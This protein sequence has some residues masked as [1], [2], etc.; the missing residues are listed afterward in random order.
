MLLLDSDL[1]IERANR[2]AQ[3]VFGLDPQEIIGRHS[4]EVILGVADPPPECPAVRM[5]QSGRRETAEL[6]VG[7]RWF[8]VV[9]DPVYDDAGVLTHAVYCIDDITERK[10]ADEALKESE[11]H[12]HESLKFQE[13][14]LNTSSI[15]I[16][17]YRASGQCVSANEAAAGII[18]ATVADL[19]AQNFHEL[20]TWKRSGLYE[21]AVKALDSGTEQRLETHVNTTFGKDIW[22]D[23]A[24]SRFLSGG[25]PHLLVFLRDIT[26]RKRAEEALR[27]SEVKFRTIAEQMQDGVFV[28]DMKGIITYASPNSVRL[29]GHVSDEMEGHPFTEFLVETEIPKAMAAFMASVSGSSANENLTLVMKR[30]N[31]SV[32]FGELAST[33]HKE[34]DMPRTIVLIRD[35]TE[36]QLANDAMQESEAKYRAVFENAQNIVFILDAVRDEHGG[37]VDWRYRDVNKMGFAATGLSRKRFVGK[38]AGTLFPER[39]AAMHEMWCRTLDMNKVLMY[40]SS[41]G[42][43]EFYFTMSRLG[44]DA[45]LGVGVDVTD[46]KRAEASIREFSG[47][48][49]SVQEEEKR[50]LS[51]GLHHDVG[52]MTV[53]VSARLQAVE[54]ELRAQDTK[55]ALKALRECR[56]V[57]DTAVKDLKKLAVDLRPPDLDV[58]GLSAALRQHFAGVMRDT[59]LRIQFTDVSRRTKLAPDMQ[60]ILF[61]IAQECVN[62]AVRHAKARQVRVRLSGGKDG[63]ALSI[64]DNGR[65]FDPAAVMARPGSRMGLLAVREMATSRGGRFNVQS[66]PGKGTTVKVEFEKKGSRG[67]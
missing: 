36:R 27:E 40:D 63:V 59:S 57:F 64:R 11:R 13:N 8:N 61:R 33:L 46:R 54:E 42:K 49:L 48:L 10:L 7:R 44:K 22:L 20:Q 47:R 28:T 50:R 55:K 16:L 6:P 18:G 19:R 39:F 23:M 66:A 65:G 14:I 45:L 3:T 43:R 4:W 31:G 29:F 62:N 1:R 56:G 67:Q 41:V 17:T 32:F 51:A 52:S 15:G 30:K 35:I 24:F 34:D 9:A 60:T 5:K 37:I 2:A 26:D 21:P 58:L 38:T 12:L 53:G 25:E